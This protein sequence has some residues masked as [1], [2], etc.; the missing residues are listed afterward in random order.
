MQNS[1]TLTPGSRFFLKDLDMSGGRLP[2]VVA[3]A[4]K[5]LP[6]AAASRRR[7]ACVVE[8]VADTPAIV[9]LHSPTA[10]RSVTLGGQ[11]LPTFAYS[12]GEQLLWVRFLNEAR[13]RELEIGF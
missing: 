3:A 2:R 11:P 9:L 5:A 10:P 1:I 8:G 4:C 7:I 12:P 6:L 13:P